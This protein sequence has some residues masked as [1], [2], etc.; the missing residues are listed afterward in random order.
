MQLAR[1]D[2][3]INLRE[4]IKEQNPAQNILVY[5]NDIVKVVPAGMIYLVGEVN[6][7]GAFPMNEHEDLTVLRALALG[8]GLKPTASKDNAIIIRTVATGSRVEVP[9]DLSKMLK[10][11]APDVALQPRDILFVRNSKSRSVS[12]GVADALV[13]MLT[14]RPGIP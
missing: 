13:R 12:L 5:P 9:V 3:T 8:E 4:L 11:K 7:P 2:V 6:R 10:G 1:T 14:L